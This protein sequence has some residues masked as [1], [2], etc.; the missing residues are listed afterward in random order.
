MA[1]TLQQY[2][3][4]E[5]HVARPGRYHVKSYKVQAHQRRYPAGMWLRVNMTE[6]DN[7]LLEAA[8]T[9]LLVVQG[10]RQNRGRAATATDMRALAR[11]IGN[12]ELIAPGVKQ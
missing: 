4:A 2:L 1:R 5:G 6:A 7:R 3:A 9:C 8:L 10:R 11:G 12:V